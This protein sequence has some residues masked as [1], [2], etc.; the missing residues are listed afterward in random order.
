METQRQDLMETEHDLEEII[1]K[2]AEMQTQN[3]HM[4]RQLMQCS[5]LIQENQTL[6][7]D[8]ALL[9]QELKRLQVETK[10]LKVGPCLSLLL[11]VPATCKS[12]VHGA[13]ALHRSCQVL[14]GVCLPG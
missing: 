12:R 8:Q 2:E 6:K 9:T 14:P 10:Q 5:Q 3:Q 4:R 13:W 1:E 11:V 7:D